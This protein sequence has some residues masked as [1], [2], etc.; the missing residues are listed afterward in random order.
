MRGVASADTLSG[1]GN[2]IYGKKGGDGLVDGT[3]SD[4]V[5]ARQQ[6]DTVFGLSGGDQVYENKQ[7]STLHGGLCLEVKTTLFPAVNS[8]MIALM[9]TAGMT[10]FS[11]RMAWT[12]LSSPRVE[13][14]Q[15]ITA[16]PSTRSRALI[17]I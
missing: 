3:G 17:P 11:A 8:A 13:T 9:A 1:G 15:W 6:S 7:D 10:L 14:G 5:F 4:T 12:L 2:M 16:P